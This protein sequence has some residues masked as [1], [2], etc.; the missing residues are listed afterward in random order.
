MPR[1]LD[2]AKPCSCLVSFALPTL[3]LLALTR[4]VQVYSFYSSQELGLRWR[5][6]AR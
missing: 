1:R 4:L 5:L 3:D 2:T 6:F